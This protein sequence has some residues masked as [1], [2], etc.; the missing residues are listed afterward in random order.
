MCVSFPF[1]CNRSLFP[2]L[3]PSFTTVRAYFAHRSGEKLVHQHTLRQDKTRPTVLCKEIPNH[4]FSS[5]TAAWS[6]C[7][8]AWNIL[9]NQQ[10]LYAWMAISPYATRAQAVVGKRSQ[11]RLFARETEP[12]NRTDDVCIANEVLNYKPIT[13]RSA[14]PLCADVNCGKTALLPLRYQSDLVCWLGW[15][16]ESI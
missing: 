5:H 2:G 13:R 15:V 1:R 7:G 6:R 14:S 12:P 9:C 8:K 11:N 16:G 10:S 3:I 4:S